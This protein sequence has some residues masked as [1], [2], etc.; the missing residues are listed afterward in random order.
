MLFRSR[1]MAFMRDGHLSKLDF[2]QENGLFALNT[3]GSYVGSGGFGWTTQLPRKDFNAEKVRTMDMWGFAESQETVGVAPDMFGEF[4]FPYQKP[5][6]ERFG[7]N[8]YGCC[9]PIDPR[10]YI[11]KEIP[12]LRRVS[13]SPW[14][15]REKI[16]DMLETDYLVSLKPSPT[17][18]ALKH[19]N[20]DLVRSE[21][22]KDLEILKS[23]H[24]EVIMKDNNTLGGSK[25]N[26]VRWCRIA[27]EEIE[28][29]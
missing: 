20:E 11:V 3:E 10:W 21:L 4:I 29:L 28:R 15:D 6:L 27:R 5:I 17:P 19:L 25:E 7:L 14:A 2:L 16:R 8:C 9:E 26:A 22:R 13:T 23:C 18:L 12:R 24:V 1:M